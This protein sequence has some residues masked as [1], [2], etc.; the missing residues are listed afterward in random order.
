MDGNI[1]DV[2]SADG[3]FVGVLDAF[4]DGSLLGNSVGN[5][6]GSSVGLSLGL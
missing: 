2:G 4:S 6:E 5:L 1:L 3:K